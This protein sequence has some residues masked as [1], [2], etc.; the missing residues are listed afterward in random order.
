VYI[1]S[2]ESP[3]P[4]VAYNAV[5]GWP[6]RMY[7]RAASLGHQKPRGSD[8]GEHVR[9]PGRTVPRLAIGAAEAAEMLRCSRDFFDEHITQRRS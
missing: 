6:A 4:A 1:Q 8:V 7:D 5:A 9:I 2:S 3:E